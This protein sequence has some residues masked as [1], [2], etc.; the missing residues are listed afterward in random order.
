M[1][2]YLGTD[3]TSR[4]SRTLPS[5]LAVAAFVALV[6]AANWLTVQYGLVPVGFGLVAT[7]GT[8]AAGLVLVARDLVQDLAGRWVVLGCIAAG[9]VL[10]AV[11]ATPQLALASAAAFTVAELVDFAVYT[12]LRR[13][14]WARAV[15]ASSVVGSVMDSVLFLTLAGFPL[16]AALPGQLLAKTAAMAAVVVPVVVVRAVSRHRQHAEGA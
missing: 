16:W 3:C 6:A 9:G 12:P 11:L 4:R 2:F 1:M 8:W 13:R 15:A 10:S 5:G 7:A 14:G